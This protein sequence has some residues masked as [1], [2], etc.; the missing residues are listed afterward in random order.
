MLNQNLFDINYLEDY[1]LYFRVSKDY[2]NDDY[3]IFIFYLWYVA[4]KYITKPIAV[5]LSGSE[6]NR[7]YINPEFLQKE[8]NSS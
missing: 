5:L 2:H 6:G 1:W 3:T 7:R 8:D 4:A